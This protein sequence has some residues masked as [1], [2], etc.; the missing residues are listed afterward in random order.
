MA[1]RDYYEVLGVSKNA[2]ED[3]IK[4]AYRKLARK[5]HP[6]VCK[7]PDAKEKF[8][9][10]SEA[11]ST[12]SDK[13]KRAAYDNGGFDA[14]SMFNGFNPFD[15]FKSHFGGMGGMG[16][17][18]GNIFGGGPSHPANDI[19]A[20]QNGFDVQ[21]SI[22]LSLKEALNGCNKT[23]T[24]DLLDECPE[25]HGRGVEEGTNVEVCPE[26][27]GRGMISTVKQNGFMTVQTMTPCPHCKGTGS[28]FTPCHVCNGQHR[29]QATREMTVRVP[30]GIQNGQRLRLPG[31]GVCGINGG[32]S[33][34]MY[35]VVDVGKSNLFSVDGNDVMTTAVIDPFT[36]TF[37]GKANVI[38]PWSDNFSI[39]VPPQT[40]SGSKT[41]VHGHGVRLKN[42]T[43]GDLVVTF[44]VQPLKNLS[45][46]QE[47]MLKHL[48]NE[49]T[50]DN[51][52]GKDK[53]NRYANEWK[54]KP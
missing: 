29:V 43:S 18:F 33:G 34:D 54:S 1:K 23:F 12:L 26:C 44:K 8:T 28:K 11:Y 48:M 50:D 5:Y 2:T 37:G 14:S 32:A 36:A 7:E 31:R 10:V 15:L 22:S 30:P 46:Q 40:T 21:T 3:E 17:M 41:K 38:T 25:C 51:I 4:T 13:D 6:D 20:P 53:Y 52:C 45:S 9:E 49:L 39:D 16:G 35:V 47:E 24:I 27:H 42:G 19:N